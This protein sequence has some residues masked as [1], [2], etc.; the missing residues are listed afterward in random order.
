[1][2][3]L[4][5]QGEWT[6]I[7]NQYVFNTPMPKEQCEELIDKDNAWSIHITNEY[8]GIK[9]DCMPESAENKDKS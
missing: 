7:G 2:W 4:T 6:Y 5:A 9:F 8:Y 1:M 3:G